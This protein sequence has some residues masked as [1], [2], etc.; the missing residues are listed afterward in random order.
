MPEETRGQCQ[1][2]SYKALQGD[3]PLIPAVKGCEQNTRIESVNK[4]LVSKYYVLSTVGP[5]SEHP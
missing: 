3:T 1:E 2:T 4:H 5:K